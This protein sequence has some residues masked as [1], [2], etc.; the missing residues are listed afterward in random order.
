MNASTTYVCIDWKFRIVP[1]PTSA[2]PMSGAIQWTS[3]RAVQP[4]M[5]SPMGSRIAPGTIDAVGSYQHSSNDRQDA[6]KGVRTKSVLGP[7]HAAA[8]LGEV[9]V[10]LVEQLRIQLRRAGQADTEREVVQ[11][12]D[13]G[14]LMVG[15]FEDGGDGSE[16]H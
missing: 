5:K 11:A 14:G 16:E 13:A 7:P 8:P 9:L 4:V 6:T 15:A 3:A 12:G 10:D 2:M 1:A